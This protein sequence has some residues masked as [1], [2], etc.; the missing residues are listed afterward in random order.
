MGSPASKKKD[1]MLPLTENIRLNA[2]K[3]AGPHDHRFTV[4]DTNSL[5]NTKTTAAR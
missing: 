3:P 4:S 1:R 5:R 2:V